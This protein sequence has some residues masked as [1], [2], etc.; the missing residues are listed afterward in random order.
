MSDEGVL[1]WQVG[2]MATAGGQASNTLGLQGM[3]S[4]PTSQ[5][6]DTRMLASGGSG[7]DLPP[8]LGSGSGSLD[9]VSTFFHADNI[10]ILSAS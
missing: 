5:S 8:R 1:V 3:G 2:S 7:K 9:Q 4:T 6:E 10:I